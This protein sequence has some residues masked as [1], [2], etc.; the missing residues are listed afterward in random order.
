MQSLRF[1]HAH[2]TDTMLLGGSLV[3]IT[4]EW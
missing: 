3:D 4:R 1:K 2:Y